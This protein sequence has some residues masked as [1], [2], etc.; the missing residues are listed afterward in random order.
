MAEQSSFDESTPVAPV[1]TPLGFCE[2]GAGGQ[3]IEGGHRIALNGELPLNTFGG[4]IGAGRL[5]GFGLAH[6]AV[7]QIRGTA[8][9]RQVAGN[10]RVS[11]CTSGGGPL[12]TAL[13][14]ARD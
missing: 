3:F 5:H 4:Q 7:G 1:H 13:L 12:A 11:V 6:E 8:G 10:P 2:I 9:A 14:L